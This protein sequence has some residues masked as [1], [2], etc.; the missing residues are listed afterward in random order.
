MTI[1]ITVHNTDKAFKTTQLSS[2]SKYLQQTQQQGHCSK[3]TRRQASGSRQCLQCTKVC[4]NNVAL[5][6]STFNKLSVKKD[7]YLL[8]G[9]PITL[10]ILLRQYHSFEHS[11]MTKKVSNSQKPVCIGGFSF[12]CYCF[13]SMQHNVL[14]LM[15]N[16]SYQSQHINFSSW[17]WKW[18]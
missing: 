18:L 3:H 16:K 8:A 2:T 6:F 4:I 11:S 10:S 13:R 5:L 7:S 12:R 15:V 17:S 1:E 14:P 9:R